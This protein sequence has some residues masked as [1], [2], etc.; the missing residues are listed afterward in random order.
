MQSYYAVGCCLYNFTHGQPSMHLAAASQCACGGFRS[1]FPSQFLFPAFPYALYSQGNEGYNHIA[2]C[3][4]VRTVQC[5][6]QSVFPVY[7]LRKGVRV[8]TTISLQ[9]K[10][11]FCLSARLHVSHCSYIS[12]ITKPSIMYWSIA[13]HPLLVLCVTTMVS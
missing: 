7:A 6:L 10:F 4:S 9:R 5:C 3:A 13:A 1:Q 11:R 12:H 2:N 8:Y